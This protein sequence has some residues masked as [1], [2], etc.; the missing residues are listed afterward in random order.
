MTNQNDQAVSA[1]GIGEEIGVGIGSR[2]NRL[3][4]NQSLLSKVPGI[5]IF[6]WFIKIMATTVGETAADFLN[7]NLHWGLA[8]TTVLTAVLFFIVLVVQ[9]KAAKYVPSV[10]WVAVVMISILGT[11]VTD[12]LTDQLGVPLETT[13]AVFSIALLSTFLMWYKSEGTL[14]I[15]SIVTAKREAF[16]WLAILFTFALGTAAGD[17]ISEGMQLGYLTSA[18]IF[19]AVIGVVT[20]AYYRFK[21]NAV[22]AFWIAYIVT[23]P[24][25]ASLG[26]YLSQSTDDGGLGFGTV[27]TSAIFLVCILGM[28]VYL[29]RSKKDVITASE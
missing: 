26:D 9:F 13:T 29:T 8:G 10:Y 4:D 19:A 2:P 20:F 15:H 6:F 7:F 12:N 5:T 14:S 27:G 24:L 17:L 21:F 16:Y 28:I 22:L 1:A 11:L 23:R 18:L 3:L 25:G